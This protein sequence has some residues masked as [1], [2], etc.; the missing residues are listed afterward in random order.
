M[1]KGGC[2]NAAVIDLAR[3]TQD[4]VHGNGA[5]GSGGVGQHQLAGHI[6]DGP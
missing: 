2:R 4:V 6:S 1:G 3:M 5:L